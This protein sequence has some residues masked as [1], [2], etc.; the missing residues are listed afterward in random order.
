MSFHKLETSKNNPHKPLTHGKAFKAGRDNHGRISVRRKGGQHKRRYRVIDF[1]RNDSAAAA[2]TAR[3]VSIEYD[4][5][6]SA[7]IALLQYQDG[8]R[9]YIIAPKGVGV[10]DVIQHGENAP[11]KIGNTLPL[12]EIPLGSPVHA[13]ELTVGKGAQLARAA[14]ASAVLMAKE[15][16]YVTVKLPSGEMRQVHKRC[17]ATIGS[18]GNEEHFNVSLGKAGRA[19]YLGRRPKVR[20]VAMNPVDHPHGGGEGR[21]SGGRHPVSPTGI[22]TKGYKTRTRRKG[23]SKFIVRRRGVKK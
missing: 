19:R 6:R 8:S 13:I 3:V 17:L 23:S 9:R 16:N 11:T 4:P 18:V 5:N 1:Y 2:A 20:G 21:T 10:G 12:A 14:G 15:H 7:L 22:P